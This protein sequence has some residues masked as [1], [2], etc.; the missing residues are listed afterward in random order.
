MEDCDLYRF[1]T[2]LKAKAHSALDPLKYFM[3][4]SQIV[5][6]IIENHITTFSNLDIARLDPEAKRA[7]HELVRRVHNKRRERMASGSTYDLAPQRNNSSMATLEVEQP[8]CRK[9]LQVSTDKIKELLGMASYPLH[10]FSQ[11]LKD[12]GLD[13]DSIIIST[14]RMPRAK[15]AS[16]VDAFQKYYNQNRDKERMS[17]AH[18]WHLVEAFKRYSAVHLREDAINIDSD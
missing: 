7:V 13:K 15:V 8:A 6:D 9:E 18:C 2:T 12:F 10:D 3:D 1:K 5:E 16:F 11:E 14:A 17:Q 4:Q